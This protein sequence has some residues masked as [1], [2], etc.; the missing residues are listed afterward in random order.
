L[1]D[2][3]NEKLADKLFCN[4]SLFQSIPDAWAIEQIFPIMPL[5]GLLE[6]PTQRAVLQDL[7]CD[8]D[9]RIHYYVDGQGIE[10]SLPLPPSH[11]GVSQCL[12]IFLVGAYQEILGDMHNLFGDTDSV[13][14][15]L[16]DQGGYQLVE[17]VLGDRVDR[18]LQMVHYEPQQL[19]QS[20]KQQLENA[21]LLPNER[22][23]YLDMLASGLSGYTY[24][25]EEH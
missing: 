19:M 14:V 17:P 7:T 21:N 12:G 25:E 24:L 15:E 4:F 1:L 20:Y 18:V 5:L 8:S 13:H 11:A 22:R 16:D 10:S 2:E 6:K 23:K 3:L 9:G